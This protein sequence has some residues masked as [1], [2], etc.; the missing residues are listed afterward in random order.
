MKTTQFFT[1]DYLQQ[2]QKMTPAQ[3]V[4]FLEEFRLLFA[5]HNENI[6]ATKPAASEKPNDKHTQ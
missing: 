4:Q 1:D 2:C 3:I 5:A 6:L